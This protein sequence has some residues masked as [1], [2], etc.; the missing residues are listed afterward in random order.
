LLHLPTEF[1][2]KRAQ[3][4]CVDIVAIRR[5]ASVEDSRLEIDALSTNAG[6][7]AIHHAEVL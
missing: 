1:Y 3:P 4:Q 6:M 7:D 5:I 2:V